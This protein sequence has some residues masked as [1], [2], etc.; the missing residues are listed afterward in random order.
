MIIANE[1]YQAHFK[2]KELISHRNYEN[3]A[4][5]ADAPDEKIFE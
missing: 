1:W 4:L 2:N 5:E 3:D